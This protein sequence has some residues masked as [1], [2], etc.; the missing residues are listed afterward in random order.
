VA[1]GL[2][3][4]AFVWPMVLVGRVAAWFGKGIRG[5]LRN[6]I[7][8]ESVPEADRGKVFGF[9]RA[10]DTI[11]AILGPLLGAGLLGLLGPQV[12]GD[13]TAPFR[14]I[15]LV[16]LIPGLGSALVFAV[17]VRERRHGPNPAF[18]LWA[19]IRALPVGYRRFLIGVGVF[20]AGDF[21]HALLILAAA[22][23]LTPEYGLVGGA[24][25]AALL[26]ALRNAAHAAAAF[27]AGLLGDRWGRRG[28]LLAG[29]LL[30]AAV[31]AGFAIVFVAST[32]SLPLLAVLFALAGV[33]ISVEEALE[34]ALTADLVPDESVRGTAYGVLGV[35][36]GL[37][38]FL[39]S[40]GVGLL[41][42]WWGPAPGFVLAA[43]LMLLG[44][45]VLARVR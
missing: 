14:T 43:G 39:S 6:A 34:P 9:H 15:F 10:G 2:F 18:R 8:A 3:A 7:L 24:Q 32:V 12:N 40:A 26:Y 23:M 28:V 19:S 36:N 13:A 45:A 42:F 17:L 5:P 20:G 22:S 41:W 25:A 30:G 37:G 31:M 29:Y 35:V 4:V 1:T 38:D 21:A 27:P 33:F 11:G 44:S 16:T